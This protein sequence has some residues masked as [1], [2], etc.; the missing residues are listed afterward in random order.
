M[1]NVKKYYGGMAEWIRHSVWNL[2]GIPVWVLIPSLT[3]QATSQQPI[4][5]SILPRSV[6][7]CSEV[8]LR[9][10]AVV[11]QAH[12]SCVAASSLRQQINVACLLAGKFFH[13]LPDYLTDISLSLE[14]S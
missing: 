10:Q 14:Y 5:L 13:L 1:I 3:L 2:V 9:A 11:L 12:I 6:N 8:T 7:E 4:Q